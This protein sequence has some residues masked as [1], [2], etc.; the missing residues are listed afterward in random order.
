MTRSTRTTCGACTGVGHTVG[1]CKAPAAIAYW[2]AAARKQRAIAVGHLDAAHEALKRGSTTE[3]TY[4]RRAALV[5]MDDAARMDRKR[6]KVEALVP[7]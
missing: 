3:A 7:R 2:T 1:R 4:H 5:A 6:A